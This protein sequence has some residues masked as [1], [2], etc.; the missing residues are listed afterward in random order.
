MIK[1][2][3]K[4]MSGKDPLVYPNGTVIETGVGF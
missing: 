3:V 1:L 4:V 2:P